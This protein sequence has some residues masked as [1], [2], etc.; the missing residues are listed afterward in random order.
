[1]LNK[2]MEKIFYKIKNSHLPTILKD[3]S[4]FRNVKLNHQLN[5]LDKI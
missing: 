4:F 5:N 2:V 1:M 3:L